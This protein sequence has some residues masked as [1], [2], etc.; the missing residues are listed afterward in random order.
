MCC[1]LYNIIDIRLRERRLLDRRELGGDE[2]A[3]C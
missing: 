3:E 1:L 2:S